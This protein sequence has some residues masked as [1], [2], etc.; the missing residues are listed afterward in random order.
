MRS[1]PFGRF[2]A[3]GC[4]ALGS[5]SRSYHRYGPNLNTSL[6][7]DP[8]STPSVRDFSELKHSLKPN[9]TTPK[10]GRPSFQLGRSEAPAGPWGLFSQRKRKE[11]PGVRRPDGSIVRH[12]RCGDVGQKATRMRMAPSGRELTNRKRRC[13]PLPSRYFYRPHA[14]PFGGRP[15]LR[16]TLTG[17]RPPGRKVPDP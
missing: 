6:P 15:P 8:A 4:A 16:D 14:G 5:Q 1:G 3:R 7:A 2:F 13:P 11:L 9:Q 10:G 12:T 17:G